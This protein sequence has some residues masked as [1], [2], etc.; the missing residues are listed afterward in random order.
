MFILILYQTI[1]GAEC[2]RRFIQRLLN[3]AE[4]RKLEKSFGERFVSIQECAEMLHQQSHR[5]S[6]D[7]NRWILLH[8]GIAGLRMLT[9]FQVADS[10]FLQ[11]CKTTLH[12][13]SLH[14]KTFSAKSSRSISSRSKLKSGSLSIKW[15][16]IDYESLED[17][18]TTS[19]TF[20]FPDLEICE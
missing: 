14:L 20:E 5:S 19:V 9:E 11:F 3:L 4:F 10:A 6:S 16:E 2:A 13:V 1:L 7:E 8:G 17:A 18:Y 15:Q 12:D